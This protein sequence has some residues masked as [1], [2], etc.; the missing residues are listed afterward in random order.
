MATGRQKGHD[1]HSQLKTNAMTHL[2]AF[3]GVDQTALANIREADDGGGDALRCARFVRVEVEQRRGGSRGE[4]H[5][6]MRA[7]GAEGECWVCVVEVF[8][9]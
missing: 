3:V 6:L 1:K 9:P 4:V 8:E 7:C 5:A 2:G